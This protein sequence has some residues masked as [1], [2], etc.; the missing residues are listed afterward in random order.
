MTERNLIEK[1]VF[2][3]ELLP[4]EQRYD[5]WRESIGTLF[6][7][8]PPSSQTSEKFNSKLTNY[9]LDGQ[10][11][12]SR[13]ET[14]AQRFERGSLRNA[15][16]GLDYYLIQTHLSGGQDVRRGSKEN[17][18]SVGSL[19][20]IDLADK[21]VA[22]ASDFSHLTLV[23]PRPLLAPMLKRPDSQEGRVLSAESPLVTFAIE[24]MKTLDRVAG[25]MTR[26]E[27]S[28]TIEPSL[29]LIASAL[30]GSVESVEDGAASI[31]R[32]SLMR[33]K[34]EIE[35]QLHRGNISVESICR[36]LG[37]SRASLYRLF[38]PYGGIQAYIRERRLVRCAEELV[39]A[40][41]ATRHIHD[42]AFSWGF[43]SEAHFSRTFKK[44]FGE[45]PSDIR[46]S[47]SRLKRTASGGIV[48]NVGDRNYEQWL[49]ETLRH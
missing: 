46:R 35:A 43:N 2:S 13:C 21:H 11:M 4:V 40:K 1:S 47:P 7:V 3:T 41:F 12:F 8:A 36:R 10:V 27:A 31:A 28:V 32:A 30:N 44:R 17:N 22:E 14:S 23:V 20:V 9:L 26:E 45:T 49:K 16:D 39:S 5:A 38:K 42:I 19:M 25:S 24:H 6:D 34:T 15:E 37:F 48:G 33:A 29:K 18:S